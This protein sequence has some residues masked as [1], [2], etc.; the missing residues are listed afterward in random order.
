LYSAPATFFA[1]SVTIIL[2]FLLPG[3]F[4]IY[5]NDIIII[6]I[7][8]TLLSS[9]VSIVKET[10][11]WSYCCHSRVLSCQRIQLALAARRI[12][13]LTCYFLALIIMSFE[14]SAGQREMRDEPV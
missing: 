11:T 7:S 2:T 4:K 8:L 10:Y 1:I 5:N 3:S 13:V 6:I 12:V 9:P 14:V